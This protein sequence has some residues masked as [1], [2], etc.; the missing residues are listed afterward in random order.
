VPLAS[1]TSL[2]PYQVVSPLGS[3]GMGEVYKARDTRLDRTVAIKTL[4]TD[5]AD[6]PHRRERFRREAQAISRLSHPN[7]CHLY[8]VG[9]QDGVEFL[10]MEYLAGETLAHRLLRG[11]LP[12]QQALTVAAE[13]AAALDAAHRDGVI[14]RDLKP[15][16]IMLTS[17]GAKIL[18]FGVAKWLSAGGDGATATIPGALSTVTAPGVL[19]GTIQYMSPEQLEGLAVDSRSDLFA[20]GAIIYE[21]MTGRRAFAGDQS[22]TVIAAIL[23]SDPPR[24]SS[25]N[26]LTP[27]MLDRIVTKCLAKDP[28]R[29]W[30]SASD[31]R[32]E[33]TW[34]AEAGAAAPRTA[35]SSRRAPTKIWRYATG[36]LLVATGVLAA[37][38]A[39]RLARSREIAPVA[40]R[41]VV[42][43]PEKTSVDVPIV[44]PDGRKIAF[45]GRASDGTSAL[46]VRSLESLE[47]RKL[48]EAD[49]LAFPFW[50]P[51]GQWVAFFG[52]GRLQKVSVDG[53]AS[54]V[55]C[56][57]PSGRGGAWSRDGVIVFA[58]AAE[59]VL[60]RVAAGGG[61]PVPAT[62]LA[63]SPAERSHRFPQF[64]PDSRHF[65]YSAYFVEGNQKPVVRAA[66]LES[67]AATTVTESTYSR[68]WA[69]P[70]YL[71]YAQGK[72]YTEQ[73]V[74]QPFDAEHLRLTG[75]P[76]PIAKV[77]S[78]S[79]GGD[80]ALSVSNNGVLA[81]QTVPEQRTAL[82]WF[83]RTGQRM[84]GVGQP[85][86]YSSFAVSPDGRSV[87]VGVR[88]KQT[89]G[90]T[91]WVVD[92]ER[93]VTSRVT[94]NGDATDPRWSPGSDRIAF[95][96]NVRLTG[97][98]DLY[99][100]AP[101]GNGSVKPLVISGHQNKLPLDWSKDGRLLLFQ[102]QEGTSKSVVNLWVY[103]FD[104]GG[105]SAPYLVTEFNK[106]G[107]RFS[108]DNR[109]VA[110]RSDLSGR[111][112]IYVDTFPNPTVRTQVSA[113]GGSDP[114]WRRDGKELFYIA[115]DGKLMAVP[116]K[117]APTFQ[118]GPPVA[119]FEV[120]PASRE[121]TTPYEPSA[122]GQRFLIANP[123]PGTERS[124]IIVT[125]NWTA[126]L[127][128]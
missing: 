33:L 48:V 118:A 114:A 113:S 108:P 123:L 126:D 41:L 34:I 110:Y 72:M 67:T 27:P 40:T 124:P 32:D 51:D 79:V 85:E 102:S 75:E 21:M 23:S 44:S 25:L 8:D 78:G 120:P 55:L 64:L 109:L 127:K 115:A 46:W 37:L 12:L 82:T 117:T 57:A 71:V 106:T 14:H 2:G 90:E 99:E 28:A 56:D 97:N 89:A 65:I 63:K 73:Y 47:A 122:D 9:S 69:P 86:Q 88:T 92:I 45:V 52:A 42:L 91:L 18:D 10:V 76:L 4:P 30:Q 7:I 68:A 77:G 83:G 87:A 49:V 116:V 22:T 15:A 3:G 13:L 119:L 96:S 19:V 16:N 70:G 84:S 128:K 94:S 11:P 112:E 20:L 54:L 74:A 105:H 1:G 5:V 58:P 59:N 61:T 29:R 81:H 6:D 24:L 26:P 50:S 80:T 38:A 98:T 36:T 101:D 43:P 111:D 62:T 60:Y 31:L 100:V 103:S 35:T 39:G 95:A 17:D 93:G 107:A 104:G 66:S 53:G 125:L 121:L